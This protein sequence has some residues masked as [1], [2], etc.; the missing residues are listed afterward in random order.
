MTERSPQD[1]AVVRYLLGEAAEPEKDALEDSLFQN[2][3]TLEQVGAVEDELIDAFLS[4]EL[5]AAERGRFEKAYLSVPDRRRRFDFARALRERLRMRPGVAT[6]GV[7]PAR[8][9]SVRPL[10]A[11]AA[12]ILAA[13]TVYFA[14]DS[15]RARRELARLRHEQDEI[16]RR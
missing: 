3:E 16:S 1:E 7:Y 8:R 10:L 6:T 2:S 15:V 9:L 11:A 4:G 14:W 13:L 12:V 5:D